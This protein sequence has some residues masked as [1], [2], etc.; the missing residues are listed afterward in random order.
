MNKTVLVCE[1]RQ[2]ESGVITAG[3]CRFDGDGM[4]EYTSRATKDHRIIYLERG[5]LKIIKNGKITLCTDAPSLIYLTPDSRDM[6]ICSNDCHDFWV[7]FAG[8][9][10]LIFDL[11]IS[12]DGMLRISC[13][14]PAEI[15][16]SSIESI[17]NEFRLKEP[18]YA[19]SAQATLMKLMLIFY[20]NQS[21]GTTLRDSGKKKLAPALLIMNNEISENYS[22]DY[23][24]KKCHMSKSSFLHTFSKVMDTTPIKYINE[25]KIRN[26]KRMLIETDMQISEISTALGFSSPQYFSKTFFLYVGIRPKDYRRQ[27]GDLPL[28]D[29]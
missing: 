24:A 18:G 7:S 2:A 29:K 15:I 8:L 25:R 3:Y 5:K 1:E 27:N 23:Y 9:S 26:A 17:I 21:K 6:T 19:V 28:Y 12:E 20:R 14:T 11:P 4:G 16:R 10:N 22:M 13:H